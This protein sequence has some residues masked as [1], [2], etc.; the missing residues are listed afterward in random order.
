M[1]TPFLSLA[2]ALMLIFTAGSQ[3][4]MAEEKQNEVIAASVTCTPL[5]ALNGEVSYQYDV[6]LQNNTNEKFLVDYTVIFKSGSIVKKSHSHSTILI[7][8][9][10]LTESHTGKM[11]E[12][13]WDNISECWIEWSTRN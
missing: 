2:S 11:S 1:K 13:E 8:G 5:G 12:S 9:E 10:S 3:F 4:S 7:A 6:T